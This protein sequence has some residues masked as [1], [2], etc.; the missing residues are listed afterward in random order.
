MPEYCFPIRHYSSCSDKSQTDHSR[1]YNPR[2]GEHPETSEELRKVPPSDTFD[3]IARLV[4]CALLC[5]HLW[6][7]FET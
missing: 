2:G 6:S 5:A 4:L 1:K 3:N 7:K